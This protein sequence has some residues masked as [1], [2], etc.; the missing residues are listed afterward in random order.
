MPPKDKAKAAG[1]SASSFF[2]L[3]AELAKQ[4]EDFA[5]NKAA[6]KGR[7]ITGG[8]KLRDTKQTIWARPNKGVNARSARDVELEAISKP[9]M[10]HA[11]AALERKA[12]IYDKLRK[13]KSGGLNEK[14]Y[15]G[16]LVDFDTMGPTHTLDSDSEDEDESKQTPKILDQDDPIIEYEDEFGRVRTAPR[17]E[18]PRHLVPNSG[19]PEFDEDEDVIIYNPVNHFPIY[20]PSAER[21]AAVNEALSEA[22]NPLGVHYDASAEVRAKGAGFYQFSGDE[23]TRRSSAPSDPFA[24]LEAQAKVSFDNG[25]GETKLASLSAADNFLAQLQEEMSRGK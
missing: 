17:S 9:T 7:S 21:V 18:V 16:L 8:T 12:K 2:D 1:I 13:G 20:E 25:K 11:R 10:E 3:K 23:D 15:E 6:G 4:E 5:K 19:K 24:A 14:Q 22:N